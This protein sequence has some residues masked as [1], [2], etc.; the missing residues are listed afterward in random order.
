MAKRGQYKANAKKDSV[1]QREKNRR[2]QDDRVARNR[3]RRAAERKGTVKKGDGKEI[4]HVDHNPKNNSAKNLRIVPK[5]T[6]RRVSNK[7]RK[8][9]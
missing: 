3:N 4:H 1:R 6:N 9:G 8:R 7:G 2:L 5:K